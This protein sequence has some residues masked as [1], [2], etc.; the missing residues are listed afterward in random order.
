MMVF[1]TSAQSQIAVGTQS[2]SSIAPSTVERASSGD[3]PDDPGPL[4]SDLSPVITHANVRKVA[5]K[6]A[7]WQ[8]AHANKVFNEQWT[9]AA[10]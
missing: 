4:A 3:A 10:L 5:K 6:V 8:L 9:F 2:V 7:D 1:R